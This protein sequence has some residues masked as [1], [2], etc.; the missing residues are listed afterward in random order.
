MNLSHYPS[1]TALVC[2]DKENPKMT[3]VYHGTP[4]T[5]Q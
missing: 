2:E 3:V 1:N 4:N 5:K